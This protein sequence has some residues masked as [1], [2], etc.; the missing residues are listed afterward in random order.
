ME[1]GLAEERSSVER[2]IKHNKGRR[3]QLRDKGLRPIEVWLTEDQIAAIDYFVRAQES[4]NRVE[5]LADWATSMQ[6]HVLSDPMVT[7]LTKRFELPT[8]YHGVVVALQ[9]LQY[10]AT[11]HGA[12]VE[13]AEGL[14]CFQFLPDGRVR[15][16]G[17]AKDDDE[18]GRFKVE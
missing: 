5:G 9:F 3:Q 2:A 6:K 15:L 14:E 8:V 12:S 16:P 17:E 1:E 11:K 10:L 13:D 7:E 4:A 18:V